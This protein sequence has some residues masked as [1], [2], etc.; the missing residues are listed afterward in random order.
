MR[1][2]SGNRFILTECFTEWDGK[3]W[4]WIFPED[5]DVIFLHALMSISRTQSLAGNINFSV[6]KLKWLLF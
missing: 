3:R 4:K 2:H 5:S 6:A 1:I